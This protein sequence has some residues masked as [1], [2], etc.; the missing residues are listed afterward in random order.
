MKYYSMI[1][2]QDETSPGGLELNHFNI[3]IS[4][5]SKYLANSKKGFDIL[6]FCMY[7]D[8]LLIII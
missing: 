6:I 2:N 1:T 3:F 5:N 4:G 8:P 7:T